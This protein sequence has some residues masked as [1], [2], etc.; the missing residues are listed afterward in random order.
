MADV[1]MS[2]RD[3]RSESVSHTV[4]AFGPSQ[5]VERG[6]VLENMAALAATG[7]YTCK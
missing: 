3:S 5:S 7:D 1:L 6:D 2:N 4:S